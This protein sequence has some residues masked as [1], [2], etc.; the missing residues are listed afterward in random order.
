[1]QI[2]LIKSN[3]NIRTL[4]NSLDFYKTVLLLNEK[5]VHCVS[6]LLNLDVYCT[7]LIKA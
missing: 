5:F 6:N 7:H 1:M 2:H 4:G 3:I